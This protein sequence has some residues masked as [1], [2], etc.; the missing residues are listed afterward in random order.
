MGQDLGSFNRRRN[1][2]LVFED[3]QELVRKRGRRGH[4][5]KREHVRNIGGR[6]ERGASKMPEA[7]FFL[8]LFTTTK[9]RQQP[10]SGL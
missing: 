10:A 3:T 4:S 5:D 6:K 9:E 8:A 1:F 2:E 7:A